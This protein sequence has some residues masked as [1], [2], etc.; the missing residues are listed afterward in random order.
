LDHELRVE[1]SLVLES[2]PVIEWWVSVE[3]NKKS[4]GWIKIDDKATL[5]AIN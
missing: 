1:K 5:R 2:R 3:Q 4:K